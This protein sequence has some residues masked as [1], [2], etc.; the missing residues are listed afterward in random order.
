MLTQDIV[1]HLN[2]HPPVVVRQAVPVILV[3]LPHAL[4]KSKSFRLEDNCKNDF[5]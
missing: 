2:T 1:T 4:A 5:L 3:S